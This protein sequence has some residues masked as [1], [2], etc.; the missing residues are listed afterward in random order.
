MI[1]DEGSIQFSMLFF[2]F[3]VGFFAWLSFTAMLGTVLVKAIGWA[4][5]K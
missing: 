2:R 5:E 3:F 1:I 4:T